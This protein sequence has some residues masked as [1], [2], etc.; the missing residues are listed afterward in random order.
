MFFFKSYIYIHILY[1]FCETRKHN[2]GYL[3][4][5]YFQCVFIDIRRLEM[6]TGLFNGSLKFMIKMEI[7]GD[8]D[9]GNQLM[10]SDLFFVYNFHSI[11]ELKVNVC[12]VW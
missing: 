9:F 11:T 10:S 4:D 5:E 1:I 12:I 2:N 6:A 3:S 8:Q 7:F